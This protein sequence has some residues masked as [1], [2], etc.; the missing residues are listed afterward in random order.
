MIKINHVDDIKDVVMLD[1]YCKFWCCL[2]LPK[3]KWGNNLNLCMCIHYR[4]PFLHRTAGDTERRYHL[5]YYKTGTCV[6]ET[7]SRGN[8][9][10]NGPHCAFAHGASDL[11]PPVF[12]KS[13]VRGIELFE[14]SHDGSICSKV[15]T[16]PSSS[17]VM[18][19]EK[20]PIDD[21]TWKGNYALC[22]CVCVCVCMNVYE[23]TYIHIYIYICIYIY[24]CVCVV[25]LLTC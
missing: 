8:C 19:K 12:D 6:Y 3:E 21:P 18:E 1:S 17:A 22:V 23:I 10:K 9:V 13:E 20:M 14:Q 5:R 15:P 16:S 11:R 4:C 24:V 7:D 25:Y 2:G